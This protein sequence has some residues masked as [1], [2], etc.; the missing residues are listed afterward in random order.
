MNRKF[1]L[2]I[3]MML[4]GSTLVFADTDYQVKCVPNSTIHNDVL[5]CYIDEFKD[6]DKKLNT[7]YKNKMAI[8]KKN[9]M[10][11]L[12]QLQRRWVIEK[13]RKCVVDEAN[14][15]R[16]SHFDAIQCQIDM[17]KERIEFIKKYK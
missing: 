13:E 14:Y 8:L 10:N 6:V 2:F 12:Q 11:K 1:Y 4:F 5:G 15:G 3:L 7:I 9:K 16:E 17:S